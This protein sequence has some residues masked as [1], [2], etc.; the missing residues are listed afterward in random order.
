L[1][2]TDATLSWSEEKNRWLRKVHGLGFEEVEAAI[3]D[4]RALDNFPHPDS[5]K[6]P[7]QRMLIVRIGDQV[8]VVPY[9]VDG[10]TKFLKTIYPSR[11]AKRRYS[12][13]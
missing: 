6:Y 2:I 12:G 10:K 9:V 13:G 7:A 5:I 11:K 3:E 4:R 1:Q 8:C